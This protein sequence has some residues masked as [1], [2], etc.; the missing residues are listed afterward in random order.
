MFLRHRHRQTPRAR[1]AEAITLSD[2]WRTWIVENALRG[3]SR[4]DLISTLVG[5]GVPRRLAGAEVEAILR[6]PA[7]AGCSS[8]FRRAERLELVLRLLRASAEQAPRPGE[9]ERRAGASADELYDRHVAGSRPVVLTDMLSGWPALGKW[10]PEYLAERFGEV[11]IEIMAEREA[12]PQCDRRLEVHRRKATLAEY[13]QRVRT[14]GSSN[15]VYL[16]SNNRAFERPEL[17]PLLDDL[18]PPADVFEVPVR[19]GQASLWFGP[20]GTVTPLHHDTTTILV[21][22][23]YGR[24][25]FDLVSPLSSRLV[26]G[27]RGFFADV[28]AADLADGEAGSPLLTTV[29][30]PGEALLLP[31]GWWHEV[32]ALET[33]IHVSLLSF[34]RPVTADW[35]RPGE[36]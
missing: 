6:S 30:S 15:D 34:R 16:V 3:T 20:G 8:V 5:G 2:D 17:A 33:S 18:T 25:R 19:P 36:V 10:T 14:A 22:Q 31:P 23:I 13:V 26:T 28:R 27:A 24:K 4:A 12:D 35:Y 9:I 29:L 32:T 1:A 21:C 7:W 11:E